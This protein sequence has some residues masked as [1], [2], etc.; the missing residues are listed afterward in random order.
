MRACRTKIMVG[1]GCVMASESSVVFLGFVV[2]GF[3]FCC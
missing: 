2:L 1:G 3:F